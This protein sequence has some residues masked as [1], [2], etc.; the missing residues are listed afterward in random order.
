MKTITA[1]NKLLVGFATLTSLLACQTQSPPLL[2]IP[3]APPPPPAAEVFEVVQDETQTQANIIAPKLDI[4]FVID[5]SKS[6]EKHQA[7]LAKNISKFVDGFAKDQLIDF[8]IGV[9]AIYDSQRYGSIVPEGRFEPIGQLKPVKAKQGNLR[10]IERREGFVDS[11]KETLV[12]GVPPYVPSGPDASGS[13]FEELFSPVVAAL[14]KS[15][16]STSVNYGFR[17][18]GAH[19]AIILV[20]DANDSSQLITPDWLFDY[21]L[22]ESGDSTG[23]N[24]T[25]VGVII[26]SSRGKSTEQCKRDPSNEPFKIETFLSYS[27]GQILDLCSKKFG[28]QLAQIG[29]DLRTKVAQRIEIPLSRIPENNTLQVRFGQWELKQGENPGWVINSSTQTLVIQGIDRLQMED[30]SAKLEYTFIGLDLTRDK[31]RPVL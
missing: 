11:L 28:E 24:L 15:K 20:T 3:P 25:T 19:L 4:L 10:W 27:R 7:N 29:S 8:R 6:M 16:D 23:K 1:L 17:R 26:P 12:I 9:T 21:L 14:D 13:E 31:K 22:T 18:K 30:P 2:P 5:D